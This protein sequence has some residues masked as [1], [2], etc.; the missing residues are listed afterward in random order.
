MGILNI[1]KWMVMV[2]YNLKT[3]K[4]MKGNGSIMR[5]TDLGNTSGLMVV[6]IKATT[7]M[8]KEMEREKWCIKMV[9]S[10]REIG[11]MGKNMEKESIGL[12]LKSFM[13]NG[14]VDN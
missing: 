2:Y 13:V 10:M 8:E 9:R 6:F 11:L 3:A 1:T 5:K 7:R 4:N 12:G 14:I